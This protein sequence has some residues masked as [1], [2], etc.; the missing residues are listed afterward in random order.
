MFH[1]DCLFSHI[2]EGFFRYSYYFGQFGGLQWFIREKDGPYLHFWWVDKANSGI[3]VPLF[4]D[5]AYANTTGERNPKVTALRPP[6]SKV[7][8][9]RS[10]SKVTAPRPHSKFA[11]HHAQNSSLPTP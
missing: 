3:S 10:H 11:K 6:H 7:A 8:A 9:P 1:H 4:A 2:R 5:T